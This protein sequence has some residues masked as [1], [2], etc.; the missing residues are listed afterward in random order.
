MEST[1][2]INYH[3]PNTIVYWNP[4]HKS[5]TIK[6]LEENSVQMTYEAAIEA[7]KERVALQE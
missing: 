1:E 7:M 3:E 6:P 4:R 2:E 5:Y